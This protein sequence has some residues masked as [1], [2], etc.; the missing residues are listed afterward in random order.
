M[1]I[2]YFKGD[3]TFTLLNVVSHGIPYYA[4]VWAYG[5]NQQKENYSE[6]KLDETIFKKTFF[7]LLDF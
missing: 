7:S 3:L 6:R 2:V 5:N 4:L 1:G